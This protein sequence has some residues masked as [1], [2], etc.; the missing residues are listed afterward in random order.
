[1]RTARKRRR[2]APPLDMFAGTPVAGAEAPG[3]EDEL[4]ALG[5]F[6]GR[7]RGTTPIVLRRLGELGV[8][9]RV[10]LTRLRAERS[11]RLKRLPSAARRRRAAARV[12]AMFALAFGGAALTAAP[13]SAQVGAG[14]SLQ[15]ASQ[16][17]SVLL[18]V[19][20]TGSGKPLPG[21][22]VKTVGDEVVGVTDA[23]GQVQLG[24][25]FARESVLSLERE[26]YP[27]VLLEGS[28]LSA[29]SLVGMRRFAETGGR[30]P[31]VAGPRL[32][33]AAVR[34]AASKAE[35]PAERLFSLSLEHARPREPY[36]V[37]VGTSDALA[38]LPTPAPTANPGSVAQLPTPAPTANPGSVAQL[39]TPAPTAKPVPVAQ[40]PTPAPTAT[41]VPVAQ[42]PTPAPTA[43][44]VPVAQ[45]PTPAP[46]ARPAPVAQLPTPA[47]TATPVPVA[48]LPTPAPT[49]KPAPVA[50]LPSPTPTE[51]PLVVASLRPDP[52]AMLTDPAPRPR[53]DALP[54]EAP[55]AARP[56]AVEAPALR[57]RKRV[58][59]VAA[60][61]GAKSPRAGKAMMRADQQ[62]PAALAAAPAQPVSPAVVPTPAPA[63]APTTVA[64][65]PAPAP[66]T[67][68]S[69]KQVAK[70]ASA[71]AKAPRALRVVMR[72]ENDLTPPDPARGQ[73]AHVAQP[74]NQDA[75]S[76]LGEGNPPAEPLV[77]TQPGPAEPPL[78]GL[79]AAVEPRPLA[80]KPRIPDVDGPA[81]VV[82]PPGHPFAPQGP[83][84]G[85]PGP[86]VPYRQDAHPVAVAPNGLRLAPRS[87]PEPRPG[88][89]YLPFPL[90]RAFNGQAQAS[91][92]TTPLP[93]TPP[94]PVAEVRLPASPKLPLAPRRHEPLVTWAPEQHAA[95]PEAGP[96]QDHGHGGEPMDDLGLDAQVLPTRPAP[97]APS[98][99]RPRKPLAVPRQ[100]AGQADHGGGPA[101]HG[102][103]RAP[104]PSGHGAAHRAA[105]GQGRSSHAAPASAGHGKAPQAHPASGHDAHGGR[106]HGR[107]GAPPP[108]H[109][110]SARRA[111]RV[112]VAPG[113]TLSA[114]ALRELGSATLWP[115]I[116]HANRDILVDPHWLRVGTVLKVPRTSAALSAAGA[117]V[118]VVQPGDTLWA[119]ARA[120][121]GDPRKWPKIFA[122][123]RHIIRNPWLIYPGQ[124]VVL[125]LRVA[126]GVSETWGD[127]S[128]SDGPPGA[129][130]APR[131]AAAE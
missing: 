17:A 87:A 35:D 10:D 11:V 36:A 4:A 51:A 67:T 113:D 29:T 30:S 131:T 106:A 114:L 57:G 105:P 127:L 53:A 3:L 116:Y 125:P 77:V 24:A 126:S 124:R 97:V 7:R 34:Q 44:P 66:R 38:Q 68:R 12:A 89:G 75:L 20:D 65:A 107:R 5:R 60:A 46:T 13:A 40:V 6:L 31:L 58:A 111:L 9:A 103:S 91:G 93:E 15:R 94:R 95:A 18:R 101:G 76:L 50:Q 39:P 61:D 49:A 122:V 16:G 109:A 41:P 82:T 64:A 123:N 110:V 99:A 81:T 19:L 128:A 23:A 83:G 48:Q 80:P 56:T 78:A 21:V 121:L 1:M 84:S 22:R 112:T 74:A 27:L 98:Q 73:L 100:G 59:K 115:V 52:L 88:Q 104:A 42:L 14:A 25:E 32:G 63:V 117:R 72:E 86:A 130:V 33:G 71:D 90:P 96:G 85:A 43:K 119:I 69:R 62:A 120:H 2:K 28:K 118:H 54:V 45:L 37:A 102:G 129:G 92:G 8:E 47:P 26:G 55:V 79:P 70:V 108:Q